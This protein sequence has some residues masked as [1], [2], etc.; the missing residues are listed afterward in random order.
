MRRT[1]SAC[2]SPNTFQGTTT[3]TANALISFP[4]K[5]GWDRV[6]GLNV[7]GVYYCEYRL[8]SYRPARSCADQTLVTA[9]SV[10]AFAVLAG[11]RH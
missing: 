10:R 4:E 6:L 2:S 9:A 7:K 1:T 11:L 3:E 5:E 8:D